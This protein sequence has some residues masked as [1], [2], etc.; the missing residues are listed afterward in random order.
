MKR[1]LPH[2]VELQAPDDVNRILV[3]KATDCYLVF[4][5]RDGHFTD[6]LVYQVDD[7]TVPKSDLDSLLAKAFT[8]LMGSLW[9]DLN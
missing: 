6:I 3:V 9:T 4:A 5:V 2:L 7:K 8:L 1:R